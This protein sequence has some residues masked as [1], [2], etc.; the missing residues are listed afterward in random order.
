MVFWLTTLTV[1]FLDRFSKYLVDKNMELG[2]TFPIIEGFFHITYIRNPGAAFGILAQK[3]WFF[4]I[5]SVVFLAVIVYI[6]HTHARRHFWL[7][8]TL[9]LVAGGACGNL[10]DRVQGGL[11]LDFLDFRGIWPYIFNFADSAIVVGV[12]FLALLLLRAEEK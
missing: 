12:A 5:V 2:Q 10:V 8:L 6:A 11:V 4:I 9:G 3:Q 1:L 7:A